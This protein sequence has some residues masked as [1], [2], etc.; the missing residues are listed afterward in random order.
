MVS[1]T[2]GRKPIVTR[3]MPVIIA[4]AVL[5]L[6]LDVIGALARQPLG[7]PYSPFGVVCLLTYLSV[8]FIGAWRAG[9]A[10][11]L[12]AAVMVGFLDATLGPLAA[13][14]IGPGPIGQTIPEPG[15]FAYGVTVVTAI[16]AAAGL[17]G[18]LAGTWL[19][20]RRGLR[21]SGVVPH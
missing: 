10:L 20:R 15:I 6:L 9:A 8:G 12:L 14:L 1:P 2:Q 3:V 19:E 11:G 4:A 7:F 18:A 21:S 16:A 5:L 17:I 13:W